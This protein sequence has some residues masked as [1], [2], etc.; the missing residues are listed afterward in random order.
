MVKLVFI[1]RSN[2]AICGCHTFQWPQTADNMSACMR[3]DTGSMTNITEGIA[4]TVTK[5]AL[6]CADQG[7]FNQRCK[8]QAMQGQQRSA[9]V[10]FRLISR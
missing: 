9:P 2:S 10:P 5:C 7:V 4:Y 6:L 8:Q 1:R 3:Q